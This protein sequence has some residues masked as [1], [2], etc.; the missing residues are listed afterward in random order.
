[1]N[2]ARPTA[3]SAAAT[4]MTK[5]TMSWPVWSPSWRAKATIDRLAAFSISSIDRKMLMP[6]RRV[7]APA[8]PMA[9]SRAESTR[10][11]E[12]GTTG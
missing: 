1:M 9:K 10:Y 3:A 8:A 5:K 6:L 11:Q 4:A 12:T 7:R 2:S